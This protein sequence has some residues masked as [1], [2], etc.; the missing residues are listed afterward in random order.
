[1]GDRASRLPIDPASE[2]LP[3]AANA[4]AEVVVDQGDKPVTGD[5]RPDEPQALREGAAPRARSRLGFGWIAMIVVVFGVVTLVF[6][7][8]ALL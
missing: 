8:R 2:R 3:P 5:P 6:L 4:H 7:L 1:M